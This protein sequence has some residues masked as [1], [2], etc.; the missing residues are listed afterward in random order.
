MLHVYLCHT[1]GFFP[2][3]KEKKL[4]LVLWRENKKENFFRMYLVR[5]RGRKINNR[6]KVFSFLTHQ[7]FFS[8][9]NK[10]KTE[11]K[12]LIKW[13]FKNTLKIQVSNGLASYFFLSFFSS[14]VT[15]MLIFFF[16]ATDVMV[17][18]FY[19]FFLLFFDFFGRIA[20][21]FFLF[22]VLIYLF[23]H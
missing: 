13:V 6:V 19:Y 15:D 4:Y 20:S 7:N 17:F 2:N 5:W 18:I 22:F 3:F 8:P 12:K 1:V 10:E 14:F 9:K 16:F 23:S 21:L 11:M